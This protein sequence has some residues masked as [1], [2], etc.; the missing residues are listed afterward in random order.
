[1]AKGNELYAMLH[2][3][4]TRHLE[5]SHVRKSYSAEVNWGVRFKPEEH[6]TKVQQFIY[7][8][9]DYVA[10]QLMQLGLRAGAMTVSVKRKK[11]DATT[12]YKMLGHGP[13]DNFTKSNRFQRGPTVSGVPLINF[14]THM[15]AHTSEHVHNTLPHEHKFYYLF[16]C[17]RLA[18]VD[19]LVYVLE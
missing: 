6:R 19:L 8:I 2:G 17:F 1:M 4:D 14:S 10:E 9:A 11:K 3:W 13:C 5:T 18:D 15:H 7:D 12:P 16:A